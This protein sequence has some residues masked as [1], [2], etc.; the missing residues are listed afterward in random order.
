M[1]AK[2]D[3]MHSQHDASQETICFAVEEKQ[4]ILLK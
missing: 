1:S 2:Y 4:H 3:F